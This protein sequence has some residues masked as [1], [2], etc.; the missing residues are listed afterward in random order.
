MAIC[1]RRPVCFGPSVTHCLSKQSVLNGHLSYTATNFWSCRSWSGWA[2]GKD[3]SISIG[4]WHAR[5]PNAPC[6][7]WENTEISQAQWAGWQRLCSQL[8]SWTEPDWFQDLTAT[9]PLMTW[10]DEG[11]CSLDTVNPPLVSASLLPKSFFDN[12]DLVIMNQ[13][14]KIC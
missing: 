9:G 3:A 14:W 8:A 5:R 1:L 10:H 4:L 7:R 11:H 6:K 2:S 13:R 12:E